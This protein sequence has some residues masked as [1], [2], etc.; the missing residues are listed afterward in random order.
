[1]HGGKPENYEMLE[2]YEGN[3]SRTVLRRGGASNRLI[4]SLRL[5]SSVESII[6]KN[7]KGVVVDR[8]PIVKDIEY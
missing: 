7:S 2:R 8:T 3:L 5:Y 1:M 4:L 6:L